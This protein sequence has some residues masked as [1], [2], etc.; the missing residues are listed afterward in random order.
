MEA[1]VE[2]LRSWWGEG[3][4]FSEADWMVEAISIGRDDAIV[5]RVFVVGKRKNDMGW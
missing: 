2:G 1:D 5:L 3:E 4:R